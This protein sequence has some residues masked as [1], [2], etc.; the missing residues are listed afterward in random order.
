MFVA[1]CL[2]LAVAF[3]FDMLSSGL[4]FTAVWARGVDGLIKAGNLVEPHRASHHRR[5][6]YA[7]LL[8]GELLIDLAC[9]SINFDDLICF[10]LLRNSLLS[11]WL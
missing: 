7:L 3:P 11:S 1:F 5:S 8:F 10:Y 4:L 9:S 6:D 2:Q